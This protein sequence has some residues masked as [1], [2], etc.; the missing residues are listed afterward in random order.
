MTKGTGMDDESI[1]VR[2]DL[3]ILSEAKDNKAR[4]VAFCIQYLQF[5]PLS[6]Q[7]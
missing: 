4:V 1:V 3:Q 6:M 5:A 2:V 7:A